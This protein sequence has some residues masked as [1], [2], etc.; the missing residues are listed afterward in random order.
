MIGRFALNIETDGAR[1][2]KGSLPS[3]GAHYSRDAAP[4]NGLAAY[5]RGTGRRRKMKS[6]AV[7]QR[8]R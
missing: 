2:P 4:V 7:R 1:P 5:S 3:E 6:E 8:E